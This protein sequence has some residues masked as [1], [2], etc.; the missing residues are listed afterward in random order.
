MNGGPA[1]DLYLV[2]RIL[3]DPRFER[4]GDNLI[5]KAGLDI[6]TA[7]LGGKVTVPTMSGS[8]KMDIPAG[9]EPGKMLR[10]KNKGMPVYKEAGKFGDLLVQVNLTLPQRLGEEERQLLERLREI[11]QAKQGSYV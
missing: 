10:L 5:Y 1:G 11:Q 4:E 8:V 2:L 3:P 7:I 9:T 6:Y